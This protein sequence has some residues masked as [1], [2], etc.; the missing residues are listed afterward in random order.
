MSE[1]EAPAETTPAV[2][3]GYPEQK[4]DAQ[5]ELRRERVAKP[6]MKLRRVR[7]GSLVHYEQAN[8]LGLERTECP[9]QRRGCSEITMVRVSYAHTVRLLWNA[10][11]YLHLIPRRC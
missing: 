8:M 10:L 7:T 2:P 6:R 3:V 1:C 9:Y 4:K 11:S 5:V